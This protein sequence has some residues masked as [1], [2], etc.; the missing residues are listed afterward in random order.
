MLQQ[1]SIIGGR[2]EIVDLLGG[3]GMKQVWLARD[4]R[5]GGR[6]C[7][8]AEM[9]DSFRSDTARTEAAAAF[10]GEAELLAS[11]SSE[12][13]P[14]VY[15]S[16]SEGS[17]HYLVMEYVRGETLD[18]Q[19]KTVGRL[20]EESATSVALQI[21]ETLQYLHSCNPPV[22]Y[23]DLKPSNVILK[24]SGQLMLVDFGIARHFRA[25]TTVTMVGTPGY[26]APEQWKGKAEPRSDVYAL[27][28]LLHQ[29]LSGR[30][31]GAEPPFSFPPLEDLCSGCAS[32][33]AALVNDSLRHDL[34]QRVSSIAV[35]RKRL[36]EARNAARAAN[37]AAQASQAATIHISQPVPKSPSRFLPRKWSSALAPAAVAALAGLAVW[38]NLSSSNAPSPSSV[39]SEESS[40][41]AS[42][43][44]PKSSPAESPAAETSPGRSEIHVGKLRRESRTLRTSEARRHAP[45]G[46]YAGRCIRHFG[47]GWTRDQVRNLQGAPTRITANT[48]WYG[49]CW[50]SFS[51]DGHVEQFAEL[52]KPVAIG[53]VP[54]PIVPA[55]RTPGSSPLPSAGAGTARRQG[56]FT[57]GSTKNDVLAIQGT[58]GRFTNSSFHYGLSS[59]YFDADG[60]VTS[61]ENSAFKEL[62]VRMLPRAASARSYFTIGSS[63][64]E[65]LA[66]QGTPD[67]FT[68][69]SFH[70][71]LSS[72]YFD[73]EGRVTTWENSAFKELKV[74]MG[75]MVA[76]TRSYFTIGSSKD[77]VLAVQ[78][79]PDRF[80][81]SSFRYGLSSV[82]F[83]S[84]GRVASWEN[85]AFKELK[86]RMVP[87]GA[88]GET[89]GP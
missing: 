9:I 42:P 3:G 55:M 83:D 33:I 82:Y 52:W 86:V 36:V 40:P 66:I 48:W 31:P 49:T 68:D 89:E 85:S 11:L 81:D 6:S 57:I 17:A 84:D 63:R 64:D 77:E 29:M 22:I 7:A 46:A 76:S 13:I 2:Y 88:Y 18:Q 43:E 80:T 16:F 32:E 12:R 58:P 74:R 73:A 34:G 39:P 10:R 38:N 35:F 20:S 54:I 65:V 67:R 41:A 26:A 14:Q 19:L 50:V 15:D 24:P 28:A 25:P 79:T 5:L 21:A 23:R 62:K 72:V 1:G 60:K 27:G 78:G 70:Y 4:R 56:Y 75:P 51:S 71:G 37:A 45:T 47:E 30:D 87:Q 8:L 59:V 44:P 53:D 69:T 61:W